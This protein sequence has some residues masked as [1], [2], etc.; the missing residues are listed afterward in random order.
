MTGQ[1][2]PHSTDDF[3]DGNFKPHGR[4]D[5]HLEGDIVV[6][7]AEGP[8]N[9]EAIVALGKARRAVVAEWGTE[10][11]RATIVVFRTSMLMSP[12]A[13][14][15]YEQ[16]MQA[17]LAQVKPHVAVA[18]VVAPEVEGRSIMLP[19]F[20][21]IFSRINVPWQAFEE[22]H[23]AQVWARSRLDARDAT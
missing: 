23:A 4:L 21:K 9:L 15:A 16:G 1:P 7:D 6:Y 13:L 22:L 2:K 10:D 14:E 17:H 3:A 5:V 11:R 20:A 19:Y 18:W 12:A 8:F